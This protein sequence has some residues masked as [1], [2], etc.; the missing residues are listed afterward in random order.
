VSGTPTPPP[1]ERGPRLL[2][3]LFAVAA[4]AAAAFGLHGAGRALTGLGGANIAEI[5]MLVVILLF[6]GAA[7]AGR[8]LRPGEVIRSTVAWAVMFLAIVTAYAYRGELAGVGGRVLGVLAPGVPIAGR[9]AGAVDEGS[10]VIIRSRQGHFAV[11][12]EVD[13]M[14]LML[15]VDTGASFV[16]LTPQDAAGIGL[17]PAALSYSLPIRTANGVIRAAPVTIRHLAVGSIERRDLRALVAP[18]GTLS[19]SL[20]GMSF[21]DT[22]SGYGISGDR[23]TLTD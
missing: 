5:G 2:F 18:P 8:G 4:T 13:D 3:L 17:D 7:L 22:L 14:P 23:M 1:P 15:M 20:L 21:L 6:V 10:V 11:R 19:E 12:A 9:I 16:T